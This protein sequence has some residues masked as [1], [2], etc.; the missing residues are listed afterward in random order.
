VSNVVL[1]S[2]GDAMFE[3]DGKFYADWRDKRGNRKRKS[4]TSKRAA[5]RHEEEQK[6][7][8]H[9]KK[10]ARGRISPNSYVPRKIGPSRAAMQATS[11]QLVKR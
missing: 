9:P 8:A 6:E 3:K 10:K 7:L 2:K 1:Y 11:P 4:F 5:L